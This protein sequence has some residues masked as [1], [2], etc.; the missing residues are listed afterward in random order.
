[1]SRH[2][3]DVSPPS[4]RAASRSYSGIIAWQWRDLDLDTPVAFARNETRLVVSC[5]TIQD[6]TIVQGE[7][8]S[9]PRTH[10]R[11]LFQRALR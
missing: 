1:M 6:P 8:G 7:L 9:M 2:T 4:Y 10:D 11:A 3:P 5:R